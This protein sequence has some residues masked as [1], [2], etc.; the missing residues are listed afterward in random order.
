MRRSPLR[1]I[2]AGSRDGHVCGRVAMHA[3]RSRR[4]PPRLT[5]EQVA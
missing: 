1:P 3:A 2:L 4:K 5:T